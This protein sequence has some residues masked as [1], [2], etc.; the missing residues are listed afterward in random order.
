M[1]YILYYRTVKAKSSQ[2]LYGGT[3]HSMKAAVDNIVQTFPDEDFQYR[4]VNE[5]GATVL[6]GETY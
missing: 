2:W 6:Q 5:M 4:I 1:N 3:Y